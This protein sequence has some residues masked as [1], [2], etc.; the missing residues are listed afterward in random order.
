[1]TPI[2]EYKHFKHLMRVLGVLKCKDRNKQFSN[3]LEDSNDY[4]T[5]DL[6]DHF[7]QDWM[8][9]EDNCNSEVDRDNCH[10]Y[11]DKEDMNLE[12]SHFAALEEEDSYIRHREDNIG[13]YLLSNHPE[14]DHGNVLLKNLSSDHVDGHHNG[15][16]G[17][18]D[19]HHI[20]DHYSSL[21]FT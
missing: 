6:T 7:Q 2:L 9:E 20:D 10:N 16:H 8:E 1:M 18:F 17:D 21:P 4:H 19:G 12:D 13:H 15:H 5:S 11:P 3:H 14:V